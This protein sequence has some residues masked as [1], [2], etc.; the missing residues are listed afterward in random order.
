[1][2]FN[3]KVLKGVL[4]VALAATMTMSCFA[5]S[6]GAFRV[7]NGASKEEVEGINNLNAKLKVHMKRL[8]EP[9]DKLIV[10][11]H[12]EDRKENGNVKK[13]TYNMFNKL[14]KIEGFFVE[15]VVGL[16]DLEK[17]I[18]F[19]MSN[20]QKLSGMLDEFVQDID[21]LVDISNRVEVDYV[22]DEVYLRNDANVDANNI[23]LDEN[24]ESKNRTKLNLYKVNKDFGKYYRKLNVKI[25]KAY[26]FATNSEKNALTEKVNSIG[27]ENAEL[28]RTF[29][30]TLEKYEETLSDLYDI[31][32]MLRIKGRNPKAIGDVWS[33]V[34]ATFNGQISNEQKMTMLSSKESMQMSVEQLN[35]A[36]KEMEKYIANSIIKWDV[37]GKE[38]I[39]SRLNECIN[40]LADRQNI[41]I[42]ENGKEKFVKEAFV[43][44]ET[45]KNINIEFTTAYLKLKPLMAVKGDQGKQLMTEFQNLYVD[46]VD[47]YTFNQEISPN[48]FEAEIQNQAQGVRN[49]LN[50]IRT[51]LG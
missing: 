32:N 1:M 8:R 31:K 37:Q 38:E 22:K 46:L 30:K 47:C 48:A 4:S 5:G 42:Y 21:A 26:E 6:V 41:I 29:N 27:D 14:K 9:M 36:I 24:Q 28:L 50:Q 43:S 51:N 49:K 15:S 20:I 44:S 45:F 10:F 17:V 40:R 2:K 39:F 11:W 12:S 16:Y 3:V 7:P 23:D 19:G 25:S 33:N 13:V 18:V 34:G 35:V